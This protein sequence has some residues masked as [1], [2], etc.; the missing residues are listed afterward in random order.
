[1]QYNAVALAITLVLGI[2]LGV[3]AAKRQGSWQDPAAI[4]SFLLL[5]SF[6][7]IVGVPF[8]LHFLATKLGWLPASGW[9]ADCKVSVN[10]L[11]EHY[12]CLGVFSKE[13]IIPVMALS[14]PAVASWARYTR[15][16]TLQVMRED[17]VRTARAKG[18]S[19]YAVMTRHVLRNALLPLSTIIAFALVGLLEG[20]FFIETLTGIPGVGR[21]AFE[22]IGGRDYDMIMAITM[23]GA[24]SFVLAS[25]FIDVAYT[26]IDPRIRYG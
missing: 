10:L 6:P 22:S 26:L 8:M 19:E 12:A 1:V 25:I 24:S 23:I 18:I 16:F 2:P 17:Y 21:L 13:A 5:Q 7:S 11:G 15:A 4:G 14:I 3:F 20:A 9:P